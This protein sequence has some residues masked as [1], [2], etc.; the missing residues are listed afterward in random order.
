MNAAPR[1]IHALRA[2]LVA[3]AALFASHDAAAQWKWVDRSGSVHYGDQLPS[4]IPPHDVLERPTAAAMHTPASGPASAA[5]RAS[6]GSADL[7]HK[8]QQ[9]EKDRAAAKALQRQVVDAVRMHNCEQAR[10]AL[11]SLDTVRPRMYATAPDGQRTVLGQD[12][13]EARRRQAEAAVNVY[14]H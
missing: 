10:Q 1:T 5:A 12:E 11:A 3:A 14:C 8:L 7:A 4:D 6:Q 9:Q 13:I 2:A